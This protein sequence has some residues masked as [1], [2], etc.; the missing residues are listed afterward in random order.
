MVMIFIYIAYITCSV[1]ND[2]WHAYDVMRS[3]RYIT[4]LVWFIFNGV[5][6][7]WCLSMVGA[8]NI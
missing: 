5:S 4:E 7:L 3:I 2:A 8:R 1:T 6:I